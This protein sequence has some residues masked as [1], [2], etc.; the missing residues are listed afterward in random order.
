MQVY[1]KPTT[2]H[3]EEYYHFKDACYKSVYLAHVVQFAACE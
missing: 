3:I 1:E 2:N